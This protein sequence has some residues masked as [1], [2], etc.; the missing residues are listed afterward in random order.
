MNNENIDQKISLIVGIAV[1]ILMILFV[2]AAVYLPPLFQKPAFDFV[3]TNT[4]FSYNKPTLKV[5]DNKL[6]FECNNYGGVVIPVTDSTST[7][8]DGSS[9][10]TSQCDAADIGDIYRY[11]VK[12]GQS[13]KISFT[14]A[15]KLSLDSNGKSTDGFEVV[16]GS[17]S[18]DLFGF[19]GS[20][21]SYYDVYIK[22]HSVRKKINVT[23]KQSGGYDFKFLGWVKG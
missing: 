22:G 5:V 18:G 10:T 14:D 2:A 16:Q 12:T 8:V 6:T 21:G 3:Y 1:P 11:N 15:A 4:D 23:T 17:N 19:F 20:G 13:A 9:T 7:S